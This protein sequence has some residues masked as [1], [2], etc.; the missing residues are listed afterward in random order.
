MF[1][2]EILAVTHAKD[3][4][5]WVKCEPLGGRGDPDT[6]RLQMPW[7]QIDDEPPDL[8]A[9][10]PG[11]PVGDTVDM[12]VRQEGRRRRQVMEAEVE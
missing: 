9:L 2:G 12:P 11:E 10:T 4:R 7:R 8:A 5:G 6:D 3:L 1:V